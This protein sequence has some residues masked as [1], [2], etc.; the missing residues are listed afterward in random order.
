MF[1]TFS[2]GQL[3]QLIFYIFFLARLTFTRLLFPFWPIQVQLQQCSIIGSV[4]CFWRR[5]QLGSTQGHN[6]SRQFHEIPYSSLGIELITTL[7]CLSLWCHPCDLFFNALFVHE[8][9]NSKREAFFAKIKHFK[10]LNLLNSLV[11]M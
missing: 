1:T 9:I 6:C 3:E 7:N 5:K 11:P 4:L 10:F 2:L 8:F